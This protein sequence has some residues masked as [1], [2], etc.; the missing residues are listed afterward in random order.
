MALVIKRTSHRT[1]CMI[2]GL[3]TAV[4]MAVAAYSTNLVLLY[5]SFVVT[6]EYA[7]SCIYGSSI[8]KTG[9]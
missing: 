4:G 2:G 6:G 5:G 9:I 7:I 1:T 3:L 8:P